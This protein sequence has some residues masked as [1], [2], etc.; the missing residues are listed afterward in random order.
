[1][2]KPKNVN[3]YN[4]DDLSDV[5]CREKLFPASQINL[6]GCANLIIFNITASPVEVLYP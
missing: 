4:N 3:K 1:M 2:T 5:R 6:A